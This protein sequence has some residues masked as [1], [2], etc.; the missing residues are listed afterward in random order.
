MQDSIRGSVTHWLDG[1]RQGDSLA[2]QE[3]WNRYFARLASVAH[4][5][6]KHLA[7]ELSSE[8][9]A[10]SALKSVMLGVRK[11]R[12]PDLT[13]RN[14]LWPLLVTITARKSVSEQRRQ[15]AQKRSRA[16]EC[17]M[18]DLRDYIG[19]EPS[20]EFALEVADELENLVRQL[21]DPLLRIVVERKLGGF[22]NAEIAEEFGCSI[23]T[24]IRKLSRIR[25]EWRDA[26][27]LMDH[28]A[29]QG[30]AS[31]GQP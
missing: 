27:G 11:D 16:L 6:L 14:S 29:Q 1:L 24:V 26:S 13:D 17:R 5:R 4:S 18:E 23:R 9:I 8:D 2:A 19:V 12:Y 31:R 21:N 3:L 30:K 28:D 10:L 15:L 20:P 7:R 25:Q 22:S